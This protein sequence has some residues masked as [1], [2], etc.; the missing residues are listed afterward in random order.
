MA[1]PL[2]AAA[3][4]YVSQTS[5]DYVAAK[6][7]ASELAQEARAKAEEARLAATA[8]APARRLT[9]ADMFSAWEAEESALAAEQ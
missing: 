4:G 3:G 9:K 8:E 1:G 6:R 2:R 7:K 5:E